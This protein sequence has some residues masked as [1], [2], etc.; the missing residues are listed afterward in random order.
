MIVK[1][2]KYVFLV[3]HQQYADFLNKIR[4]LGVLHIEEKQKGI[5]ENDELRDKMQLSYSIQKAIK[6]AKAIIP[7]GTLPA[8]VD[9]KVKG[10]LLLQEFNDFEAKVNTLSQTIASTQ[11]EAE[12]INVWGGYNYSKIDE[13]AKNGQIMQFFNCKTSK[14]NTEWE[15]QYNAFVVGRDS[16]NTYFVTVNH[17]KIDLEAADPIILNPKNSSQL[18]DEVNQLKTK[19]DGLKT[20]MIKWAVSNVNNLE[21]YALQVEQNIDYEKVNLN[22]ESAVEDKVMLLEGY[23]PEENE[24]ALD[25][26]LEKENVYY[27]ASNPKLTDNIP[28]KLKN[29]FFSRLFEPITTLYSLPN[30]SELDDTP[31]LA[32]FFLLFFG[33]CMGDAGYGLLIF[34]VATYLRFKLKPHLKPY[35][36]LAQWF[37]LSTTVVGLVTGVFFGIDLSTV[38]WKWLSGVQQYFVTDSNYAQYFDGKSPMMI[39]ALAIGLVQIFFG[40]SIN[41]AKIIKQHGFKYAVGHIAW[42]VFLI[43]GGIIL[44]TN[45][46]KIALPEILNGIFLGFIGIS[47]LIIVFYNSPDAYNK[48][49][50]GIFANIGSAVW[51]TYNTAT[52]LL[53]DTLSYIRLFALGL[54]SFIL[55]HVFNQIGMSL[56]TGLPG[57]GGWIAMIAVLLVGHALN[58]ALALIASLVHPLRLTFV[59]FYKNAGFEGGGKSYNPFR[60][61]VTA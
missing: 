20:E 15:T 53:G 9:N 4:E 59:E 41:A 30:Y 48:P 27:E 23:C 21:R 31:F 45:M 49:I 25:E 8:P 56:H 19:V 51:N 34:L 7:E 37:A 52:G 38:N 26:L 35:A 47:A 39:F 32:P 24:K 11:K 58:I 5:K 54:T 28:I 42:I 16:L 10:N 13:L 2:K 50:L 61:K 57:L 33:L 3:F 1:M 44:G 40:M 46:L 43:F 22:T 29:N 14:Y 12:R 17:E 60:K 36:V 55:G 6:A 18:L